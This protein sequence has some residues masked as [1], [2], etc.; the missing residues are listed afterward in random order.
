MTARMS[1]C[2]RCATVI[3]SPFTQVVYAQPE[4]TTCQYDTNALGIPS[5]I[6]TAIFCLYFRLIYLSNLHLREESVAKSQSSYRCLHHFSSLYKSHTKPLFTSSIYSVLREQSY[7]FLLLGPTGHLKRL[8][9]TVVT[10]LR[11]CTMVQ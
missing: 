7:N 8:L 3:Y 2:G 9:P 11:I 1:N 6:Y 5:Y 4:N 10:Q